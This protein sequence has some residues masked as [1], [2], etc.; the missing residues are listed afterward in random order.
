ML[1]CSVY[2]SLCLA[3]KKRGY[4][5]NC[6]C[7]QNSMAISLA[8][9]YPYLS[10]SATWKEIRT[11]VQAQ[12]YNIATLTAPQDYSWYTWHL[13]NWIREGNTD[14]RRK[15]T[16]RRYSMTS[17]KGGKKSGNHSLHRLTKDRFRPA[18]HVSLWALSSDTSIRSQGP[19]FL[20]N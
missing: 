20:S 15:R 11:Y 2:C 16:H 12:N 18:M 5:L 1:V 8:P 3:H 19:K 17:G 6:S 4:L 10:F 7:I 14:T 9:Q 13:N